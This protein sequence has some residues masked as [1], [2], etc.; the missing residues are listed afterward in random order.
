MIPVPAL[1]WHATHSCNFSCEGCGHFNNYGYK[2]DI[3]IDRIEEWFSLWHKR[4]A[5]R[6]LAVLGGEPLLNKDIIGII[7][8]GRDMWNKEYGTYYEIVTNGFLLHKFPE[9]PKV[10]EKTNCVLKIS[11]HGKSEKYNK[12]FDTIKE[13]VSE[14]KKEYDFD[15]VYELQ[16]PWARPYLGQGEDMLPYEDNNP[17]ESWNHCITGQ[18][19]FNLVDGNIYKCSLL[20]YLPIMKKIFPNLSSKWDL[21]LSYKPLTPVATDQDIKEFFDRKA[22]KYCGMCSAT[23]NFFEKRDPLIPIKF[24]KNKPELKQ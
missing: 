4:I 20:A 12:K 16:D 22:E 15:V 1:E 8:L 6:K 19:C 11:V 9:L 5:P 23:W 13:L 24:Y 17:E 10:L 18:D 3:S 7:E 2:E 14:W 21:Y